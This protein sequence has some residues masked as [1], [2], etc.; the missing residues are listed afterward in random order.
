ME[1]ETEKAGGKDGEE[2]ITEKAK[3]A[4]IGKVG[5]CMLKL[6]PKSGIWQTEEQRH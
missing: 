4:D 3:R 2:V 1:G 6:A 5:P